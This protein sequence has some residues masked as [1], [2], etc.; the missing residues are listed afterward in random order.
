[1]TQSQSNSS[2]NTS[3]TGNTT[4]QS[5]T[6]PWGPTI[7]GLKGLIGNISSVP[8]GV[9]AAQQ[10]ALGQ[11][12]GSVA[13][14]PNYGPTVGNTAFS[15]LGGDP[16][17]ILQ[18]GY[19]N[20]QRQL[21]PIANQNPNPTS[22]P[23]VQSLLG[24]IQQQVLTGANANAA[25][26]GRSLN[27]GDNAGAIA[28]GTASAE[29]PALLGQ[30]NTNLQNIMQAGNSLFTGGVNTSGA[31]AGN[32]GMGLNM[33][34]AIPAYYSQNASAQLNAANIAQ[35]LQNQNIAEKT[36]LLLPISGLGGQ[37]SGTG[38]SNQTGTGVSNTITTPS[39]LQDITGVASA[40]GGLA[41]GSGLLFGGA[42]PAANNILGAFKG[43]LPNNIF[44]G[45]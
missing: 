22:D 19:A 16:Y 41:G 37:T 13:D 17:N 23:I 30:Y 8:T 34:A 27:S 45:P 3:Q 43:A 20:L 44:G 18:P 28:Y 35:Q 15:Y 11:L 14:L 42:S 29:L 26:A 6:S 33:A 5:N 39:V 40:L 7:G 12:Q 24:N 36:N 21:S 25:A 38:T 1:M 32:T 9:T 31:M 2:T 4:Q 10:A